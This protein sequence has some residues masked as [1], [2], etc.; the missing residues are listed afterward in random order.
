MSKE[1][2]PGQTDF[3]DKIDDS[4]CFKAMKELGGKR[5]PEL[6]K[7]TAKKYEV[8]LEKLIDYLDKQKIIQAK[9]EEDEKIRKAEYNKITDAERYK[10][11]Q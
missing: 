9:W 1:E 11:H 4:M 5:D 6:L 7:K 3:F 8:T 2:I 10:N